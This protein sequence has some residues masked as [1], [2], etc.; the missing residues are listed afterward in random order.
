VSQPTDD[1]RRELKKRGY[2][3]VTPPIVASGQGLRAEA[4]GLHPVAERVVKEAYELWADGQEFRSPVRYGFAPETNDLKSLHGSRVLRDLASHL[5]DAPVEPT[6]S[7][8]LFYEDGDYIGLHTD[9]PACELT[10]L[11]AIGDGCPPLVVHPELAGMPPE[12]LKALS[13]RSHGAPQGGLALP[14]VPGSVVALFGG[15]L[16]HQTRAIPQGR[17]SI[18]ATLC[19]AGV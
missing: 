5:A 16:P 17:A 15:G 9:L 10:L 11:V 13:E 8:Y 19:Y 1:V 4:D 3:T 18:V 7:G 2:A 14:I 6:Y 12:E